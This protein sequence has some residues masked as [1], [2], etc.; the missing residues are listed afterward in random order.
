MYVALEKAQLNAYIG[1]VDGIILSIRERCNSPQRPLSE[2]SRYT[3][4]EYASD[5]DELTGDDMDRLGFRS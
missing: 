5:R 3:W 2:D 1:L 4:S